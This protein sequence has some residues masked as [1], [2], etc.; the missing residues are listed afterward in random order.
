MFGSN[1][2]EVVIGLAL[3]FLLLSLICSALSELV[4]QALAMRAAN[5]AK[6]FREALGDKADGFYEHRLIKGLTIPKPKAGNP[7][8]RFFSSIAGVLARESG[9][10]SYIPAH[11]FAV[12]LLDTV[13]PVRKRGVIPMDDVR[14]EAKKRP[15]SASDQLVLLLTSEAG[16]DLEKARKNIEKWYDEAMDRVSGWYKRKT[17]LILLGIGLLV[18]VVL[19]AD[20]FAIADQLWRDDTL[21]ES[22]VAAAEQRAETP[23]SSEQDASGEE[24]S[25]TPD[26]GTSLTEIEDELNE[27]N[28]LNIPIGWDDLPDGKGWVSKVLGLAF[29]AVALSLGAPFWFDILNKAI[30]LRGAGKR[31]SGEKK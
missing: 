5:L 24:T 17:Q 18:S 15:D 23:L 16:D 29:T 20:S 19:N 28:G 10:P 31:P 2:L 14:A 9:K 13:A 3:V 30:S 8:S 21:R 11:S 12:A 27:L 4:A 1:V 7:F 25:D 6:W 26:Q 22:V